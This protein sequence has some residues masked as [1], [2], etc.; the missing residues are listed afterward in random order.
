MLR[1]MVDWWFQRWELVNF[2]RNNFQS[3]LLKRMEKQV[4]YHIHSS[5][6]Q[7]A[8]AGAN[9]GCVKRKPFSRI[10]RTNH[11][12]LLKGVVRWFWRLR[13]NRLLKNWDFCILN[14][15]FD[16]E[17]SHTI[18]K[19]QFLYI[20]SKSTIYKNFWPKNGVLTQ[21]VS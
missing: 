12:L 19:S 3:V 15:I 8:K 5:T 7:F 17:I 20:N 16:K 1:K 18:Q 13:N 4:V 6:L 21:C 11:V 14:F 10:D 2:H 9:P